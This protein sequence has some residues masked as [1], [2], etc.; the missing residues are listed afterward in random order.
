[1]NKTKQE[2]AV[3]EATNLESVPNLRG[4]LSPETLRAAADQG[5]KK[6]FNL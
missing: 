2:L 6:Q 4:H 3:S 1:M 5:S